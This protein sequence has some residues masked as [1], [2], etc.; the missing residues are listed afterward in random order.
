MIKKCTLCKTEKQLNAFHK[1]SRNKL[2]RDDRCKDCKSETAREKYRK[3]PFKYLN[4]L[5]KSYCKKNN[6][7]YDLDEEF[8]SGIWTGVCPVFNVALVMFDKKSDNSY[9]LDRLDPSKGYVKE[10]VLFISA[11][12]NR[13][14]YDATIEELE[15]IVLYMKKNK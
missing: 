9:A 3:H 7:P 4:N 12:A 10:N 6:I 13:I 8:L 14:K 2:G 15:K 5:K 1:S 11:R